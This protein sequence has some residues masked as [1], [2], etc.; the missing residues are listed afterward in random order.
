MKKAVLVIVAIAL[1]GLLV[2]IIN[3][4]KG[5]SVSI[6]TGSMTGVY[7]PAGKAIAKMAGQDDLFVEVQST[8]GSVANVNA[9][10][11]GDLDFGLVQSDRQYQAVKGLADW[12][13]TG[14]QAELRSVCRLHPEVV[15]LVAADDAEIST[16]TDLKE[17]TVNIGNP[18]SGQRGNAMDVLRTAGIDWKNDLTAET[19]TAAEAGT[20]LQDGRIDA[21]FYTVGHPSGAI[22]EATAGRRKIHFVPI[23]G[24]EELLKEFPYYSVTFI[25]VKEY[26]M[27]TSK[28][29]V[30]SIGVFCTL[31]TSSRVP[32]DTVYRVTKALFE[33]LDE[34]KKLH[35]ALGTLTKEW[36]IAE[37]SAPL[38]PGAARYFREAGLK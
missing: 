4:P 18:G 11:A 31:V 22:K 34:F 2:F 9:L 37:D 30:V 14:P 24:M 16:L 21:F 3:R 6:G 32:E 23:V 20:M 35:P 5:S 17:K 28:E 29:D 26:P 36:M 25:P 33:G 27:A 38:H 15:T 7:Y 12:K 19:L 8:P 13:D 1:A 10:M